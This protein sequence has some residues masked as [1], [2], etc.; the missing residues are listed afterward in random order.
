MSYVELL[1]MVLA[2]F[3][4]C[5]FVCLRAFQQRNVAFDSPA[6]YIMGTSYLMALMEVYVVAAI[7]TNGYSLLLVGCIGTGAGIGAIAGRAVHRRM[8]KAH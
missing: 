2:G 5:G 8:F 3:A 7:A 6:R 1:P 4:M